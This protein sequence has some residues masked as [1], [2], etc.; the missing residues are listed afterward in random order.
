MRLYGDR[1]QDAVIKGVFLNIYYESKDSIK[2]LDF[3]NISD[4]DMIGKIIKEMDSY[5]ISA[6]LP[7]AKSLMYKQSRIPSKISAIKGN[8]IQESRPFI[9][10]DI[11]TVMVNN[12][13]V[14]YAAG[15]LVVKPGD[16]LTSIPSYSIQTFFS[17]NHI[18]FYPNFEERS[19]RMLFNFLSNFEECVI[20]NSRLRT[21]Y[22]HNLARFDGIFILRY[23]TDRGNKYKIKPLLRNH[24]LYELKV[25]INEKLLLRFRDSCTLLPSSLES[26]GRTLCP[27]LGPKGSIPHDDLVV[28]DLQDNSEDLI[29]YL[30]QDILI[31]GGVMLK[32]Q[33]INWSVPILI[34][35]FWLL[36]AGGSIAWSLDLPY[37]LASALF[38]VIYYSLVY[39]CI[40]MRNMKCS[41]YARTIDF[42]H[43]FMVKEK[44]SI[45]FFHK[46]C[47]L[48]SCFLF[49]LYSYNYFI[50]LGDY[51]KDDLLQPLQ[52]LAQLSILCFYLFRH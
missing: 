21:V 27:E 6:N 18:T 2:S 22:F 45:D 10:A 47:F 24:K 5:I 38:S 15:Y 25:Y 41:V 37:F 11:E 28:S 8:N 29:N 17:E 48:L 39:I 46:I 3:P 19:Q 30:R 36:L 7:E 33:E 12:V 26:L 35:R 50:H 34:G 42:F 49:F 51:C 13:H 23:Y 9:V 52:V 31:L 40:Y 4:S 20:K 16:D 14:P 44:E 43:D 32:A 1:Y